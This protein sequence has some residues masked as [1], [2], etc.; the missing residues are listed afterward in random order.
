[1]AMTPQDHLTDEG[2]Q[3]FE[4]LLESISCELQEVDK[5]MLNQLAN[6]IDLNTKCWFNINF[7]EQRKG[8]VFGNKDDTTLL[9]QSYVMVRELGTAFGLNPKARKELLTKAKEEKPGGKLA[10]MQT[11]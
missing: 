5:Y 3:I 7:P 10:K 9:N 6:A 4:D 11:A 1:M 2:K 8:N